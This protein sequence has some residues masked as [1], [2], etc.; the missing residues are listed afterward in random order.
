MMNSI[1][2]RARRTALWVAAIVLL[3]AVFAL[4]LQPDFV[5]VLANQIWA[6]F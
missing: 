1:P 5:V 3:A 6:C 4:Y 2:P